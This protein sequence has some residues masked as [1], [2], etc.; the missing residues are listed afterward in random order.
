VPEEAGDDVPHEPL[1]PEGGDER[2]GVRGRSNQGIE[3]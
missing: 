3:G 1:A 2:Y